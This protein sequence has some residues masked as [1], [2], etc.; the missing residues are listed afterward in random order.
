[1]ST[2][3]ST[4]A[5]MLYAER[6]PETAIVY[7]VPGEY[8]TKSYSVGTDEIFVETIPPMDLDGARRIPRGLAPS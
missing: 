1:M 7:G 6:H 8:N 2:K 5:T 4:L 3:L